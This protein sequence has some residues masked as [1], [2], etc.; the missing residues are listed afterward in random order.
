M[1]ANPDMSAKLAL[2]EYESGKAVI[3]EYPRMGNDL[4][5]EYARLL[6]KGTAIPYGHV[7][8][9]LKNFAAFCLSP[10]IQFPGHEKLF[11]RG[12]HFNIGEPETCKTTA[13]DYVKE[14]WFSVLSDRG[15]W[16]DKL[17]SY[18]SAQYLVKGFQDHPRMLLYVTEGNT[19]ATSNEHVPAIF[20]SLADLYDQHVITAG[21]YKNRPARCDNAE[22]SGIVCFTPDDFKKSL[23]SKGVIGGGILPRW[24]ASYSDAIVV[25]GDWP[26]R[27]EEELV[28]IQSQMLER[29]DDVKVVETDEAKAVR[30]ALT[31]EMTE[32]VAGRHGKRLIEHYKRE[33]LLAAVFADPVFGDEG[34]IT[35]SVA[36]WAAQWARHQ[37]HLRI[38]F[39]PTDAGGP[40]E[41]MESAM[42]T[43]LKKAYPKVVSLAQLKTAA[44][45]YRDGDGGIETF[46]RA[47]RAMIGGLEMRKAGVN[48]KGA[49]VFVWMPTE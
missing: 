28:T 9:C 6:V 49:E 4:I 41:R 18:G 15:I 48:S 33:C 17:S 19:L 38:R 40:V 44:N 25:E 16:I 29:M 31:A 46:N 12:W 45:A 36:M 20:G 8:E 43:L 5:S 24:T 34:V 42:R 32:S 21:S 37:L 26:P 13:L 11:I 1:S 47:Y 39:W 22:G 10:T 7:R 27:D 3:S 30:A 14:R 35:K 23:Q 2:E